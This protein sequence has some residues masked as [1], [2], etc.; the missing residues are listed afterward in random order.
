MLLG[1]QTGAD[2][3]GFIRECCLYACNSAHTRGWI[4]TGKPSGSFIL[5]LQCSGGILEGVGW[6]SGGK[7]LYQNQSHAKAINQY[8]INNKVP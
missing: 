7:A 8:N 6:K 3:D 2:S 1:G 4:C 5:R